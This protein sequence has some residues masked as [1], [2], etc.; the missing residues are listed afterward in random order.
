MRDFPASFDTAFAPADHVPKGFAPATFQSGNAL[1]AA[2]QET[3]DAAA[4]AS[5][6]YAM[7]IGDSFAGTIGFA[8]DRDWIAISLTQ[9]QSVRIDMAGTGASPLADSY[10]RLYNASGVLQA[11]NDDIT[12]GTNTNS[13]IDFVAP[14]TGTYYIAAGAYDDFFSG[15]YN[16]A[17]T[18]SDAGGP[19]PVF[20][21][22]EIADQLYSGYWGGAQRAFTVAQG[23]TLNVD[24]TQ[25]TAAGQQYARWALE[26]WSRAS[27][28]NFAYVDA[29]VG[30][31]TVHISFDDNDANSAYASSVISG[32]RIMSSSINVGTGWISGGLVSGQAAVNTYAM[33]TYIH[34]VG[35]AL[36]LGHAGNYNGSATYSTV[37]GGGSNHY[38]NDSWQASVMSYMSQSQNTHINATYA[39]VV[40]PM[41][42]DMLAIQRLY[43]APTNVG[44]G[45]TT[46]GVGSNVGGYMDLLANLTGSAVTWTIQDTGGT[47][48]LNLSNATQAQTIDMRPESIS[49]IYG[50]IGNLSIARGTLIEVLISGSGNDT[51]TGNDA[52]NTING[53]AGDDIL[54]GGLGDDQLIGG[55]GADQLFGDGG[56]DTVRY[57]AGNTAVTV[58]L[59]TG[60][61]SGG[62]AQGDT[63]TSI[64]NVIGTFLN[65]TIIGSSGANRL[66]GFSGDDLLMGGLGADQ[67]IGGVGFDT[68]SY[69]DSSVRVNVGL[70][71]IGIGGTSEG[72]I[73]TGI[74]AIIGSAFNDILVGA[75]I[76]F[77]R[78]EG[79]DGN[80]T[81]WDYGG[82]SALFGGNGNDFMV[83]LG[84]ADAFDGGAGID[85]LGFANSPGAV[86]V[87]LAGGRGYWAD[88]EGDTY[89]RMENVFGSPFNDIIIGDDGDNRLEGHGGNDILVGGGG[90]DTLFGGAGADTFVFRNNAWG[91]DYIMDFNDGIDRLNFAEAGLSY[92]D[93]ACVNTAFGVRLDYWAPGGIWNFVSIKGISAAQISEADF[94]LSIIPGL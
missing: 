74:E 64:E 27:G 56:S 5:T 57:D 55:A 26:A 62:H 60:L 3:A 58:N 79:G 29:A 22:D 15:T 48:T 72:D 81:L 69:T 50:R 73:L 11:Q 75:N 30:N 8:G 37:I 42:A 63:Y 70:F 82:P 86:K 46:Y 33:Q 65:D 49:S 14:S 16:L 68:A 76:A 52:N 24:I 59:S 25:L 23:G 35:H 67:L 80:D 66:D 93:F 83:G 7:A 41:I 94:D 9:N 10:L 89:I 92:A 53:G 45:D 43:G 38:L 85:T 21:H 1:F 51:I 78:L 61:G 36:G 17:V 44:A 28:I 71:R 77:V 91:G 88:A 6:T 12:P 47:D 19:L 13:R 84:G 34:E 20:S 31:P 90:T 18:N 87:D 40:T 39:Y 54:Y 4:N 32:G 2:F